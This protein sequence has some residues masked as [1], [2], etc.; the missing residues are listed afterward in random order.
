LINIFDIYIADIS[1]ETDGKLR[2]V[3][4]FM[5]KGEF[6]DIF[7]ITTRYESKSETIKQKYFKIED[8]QESG[9]HKQSYIDTGSRLDLPKTILE[10]KKPI[11]T[12]TDKD[13]RKF[14]DFL[15]KQL[16]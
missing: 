2:P 14:L 12:L 5:E 11:G 13:I 10:I 16:R 7:S 8:W 4:V 15:S 6:V 9:L 1:W 3:L